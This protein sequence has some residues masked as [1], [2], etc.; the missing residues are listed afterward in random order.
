VSPP[1]DLEVDFWTEPWMQTKS[2][3][4][5]HIEGECLSSHIFAYVMRFENPHSMACIQSEIEIHRF[6]LFPVCCSMQLVCQV[7]PVWGS[8]SDDCQSV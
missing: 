8:E 3:S 2:L 4:P 1:N 5:E 6:L 7:A